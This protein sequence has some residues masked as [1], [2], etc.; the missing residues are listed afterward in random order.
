[1]KKIIILLSFISFSG[2]TITSCQTS[3]DKTSQGQSKGGKISVDEFEKKLSESPDAQIADVRSEG[4]FSGGHLKGAMNLDW[5][6]ERFYEMA[7]ALDK[8]KPVFVYCQAGG[9]SAA[10]SKKF[11][12]MGF[13]EVYDMKG[14]MTAWNSAGKSVEKNANTPDKKGMTM[15]EYSRLLKSDKL[16]LVD[17]NAP[18]CAP[19][20]KM[21][22][23]LEEISNEQ[24]DKVAVVKINSDENPELSKAL[25]LQGLPTL[26]LYKKG[27]MVWTNMGYMD[28]AAIEAV[29]AKY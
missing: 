21:A 17:L 7:I 4:E 10:A 18:W 11:Q 13:T 14:G 3:S 23:Y 15:E 16:V 22:P 5:N 27:E 25:N 1:M 19:C 2:I 6:G 8:S 26:F 24:K 9:R 29:L 28:K 12:E 20:R